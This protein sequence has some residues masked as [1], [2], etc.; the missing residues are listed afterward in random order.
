[1]NEL[2]E[3]AEEH[4]MV[5]NKTKTKTILFSQARKYDFLPT[6]TV[7]GEPLE[8]VEELKLLG[9]MIRSD[10]SW[11]SNSDNICKNAFKRLWMIR[12]LKNL[13]TSE[14]DL[15]DVYQKQIRCTV[16]FAVPA[17]E[18]GLKQYEVRQI[19]R[20]QKAALA[21]IFDEKYKNYENAL[22]LSGLESLASRRKAICL[23]FAQKAFQNP[24][25]QHWFCNNP[26]KT[27]VT[28]KSEKP[29]LKPVSAR[30]DR[31]KTSPIAYLTRLLNEDMKN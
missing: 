28:T 27:G 18:S 14:L 31:F 29:D 11:N 2:V 7:D 9:V 1:M 6:I 15:L 26:P 10:L 8:V 30:T 24:K 12:R 4:E 21:I 22:T 19:E 13:G 20:V 3:Y 16:E 5:I 23:K 17:W 25:Y